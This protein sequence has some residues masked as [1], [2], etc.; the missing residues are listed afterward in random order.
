MLEIAGGIVLEMCCNLSVRTKE[1]EGLCIQE[2]NEDCSLMGFYKS[3]AVG[4]SSFGI[5]VKFVV[6]NIEPG[7]DVQF[8]LYLASFENC[9]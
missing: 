7:T 3:S 9:T 2:C 5:L 6:L 1:R 8:G 4:R